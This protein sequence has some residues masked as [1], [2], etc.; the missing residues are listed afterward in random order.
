MRPIIWKIDL[1]INKNN[2]IFINYG[3]VAVIFWMLIA[4]V[5]AQSSQQTIEPLPPD[6]PL[7][8]APRLE[9]A[10]VLQPRRATQYT[11]LTDVGDRPQRLQREFGFNAIIVLPPEAN[12]VG[13]TPPYRQTKEQ[14]RVGVIAIE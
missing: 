13:V 11:A 4:A 14:F 8:T 2:R 7:P 9:R 3:L 12:N 5:K 1:R 6:L 10:I